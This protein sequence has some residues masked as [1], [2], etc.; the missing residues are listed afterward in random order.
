MIY[1]VQR[2]LKLNFFRNENKADFVL[3]NHYYLLPIVKSAL[4]PSRP[5]FCF[6]TDGFTNCYRCDLQLTIKSYHSSI[7]GTYPNR[8][9]FIYDYK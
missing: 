3:L 4:E 1:K 8:V 2:I 5:K 9:T 7:Y 6:V